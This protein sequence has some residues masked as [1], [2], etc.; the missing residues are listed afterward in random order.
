MGRDLLR[1]AVMLFPY[2]PEMSMN[3]ISYS[4]SIAEVQLA[5]GSEVQTTNGYILGPFVIH[6]SMR[7][8]A[9]WT[10]SHKRTGMSLISHIRNKDLAIRCC[11]ALLQDHTFCWEWGSLGN[12][13]GHTVTQLAPI[14]HRIRQFL[15]GDVDSIL[16]PPII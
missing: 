10:V 11:L 5:L 16:P 13:E 12:A 14:H 7:D 2:K 9:E 3:T 1:E 8:I 6:H 4:L 15:D